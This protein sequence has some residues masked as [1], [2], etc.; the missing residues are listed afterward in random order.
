MITL[1]SFTKLFKNYFILMNKLN[2]NVTPL[3][4][5]F[6]VKFK[7]IGV[8][9]VYIYKYKLTRLFN[10]LTKNNMFKIHYCRLD[11]TKLC[12]HHPNQNNFTLIFSKIRTSARVYWE[13]MSKSFLGFYGDKDENS[14]YK[15]FKTCFSDIV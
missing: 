5:N 13:R 15:S 10:G 12:L 3:L 4:I 8:C 9:V 7:N 6:L 1:Q 14:S 11:F 2:I